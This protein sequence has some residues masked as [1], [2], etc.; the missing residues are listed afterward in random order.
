MHTPISQCTWHPHVL[1]SGP[2][3]PRY[4]TPAPPQELLIAAAMAEKPSE[5]G[6]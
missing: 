1:T 6:C 3:L 5:Q 4:L 2:K